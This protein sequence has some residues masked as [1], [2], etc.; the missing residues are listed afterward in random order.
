[1]WNVTSE[2]FVSVDI[3]EETDHHSAEPG[4]WERGRTSWKSRVVLLKLGPSQ[5]VLEESQWLKTERRA[6]DFGSRVRAEGKQTH[7]W[8]VALKKGKRAHCNPVIG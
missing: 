5:C 8:E 1:M 6:I 7:Y 3:K 2:S 4:E